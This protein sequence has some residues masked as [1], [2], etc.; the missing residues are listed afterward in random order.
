MNDAASNEPLAAPAARVQALLRNAGSPA[1]VVQ[2]A[3]TA[4]SAAE[5]AAAIGCTVAQ[6][7]KSIVFRA[8]DGRAVLV[9]TSGANRVDE[10][11]VAAALGQAI[12]KADADF[13]RAKTGY[14]IGGVSP[15]GHAEPPHVFLDADLAALDPIWAAAGHPHAV[16]RTSFAEL[17]RLTG[18]TVLAVKPPPRP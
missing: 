4:R 12:G 5:A 11:A 15:I 7:A 1:A 8:A 13:V 16:F 18:G 9:V 3:A 14:V 10:K 2:F 17:Q 6:I